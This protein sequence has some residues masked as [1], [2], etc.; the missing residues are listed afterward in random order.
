MSWRT[1]ISGL[2][3]VKQALVLDNGIF[4]MRV[5]KS[6]SDV[7]ALHQNGICYIA[8]GYRHNQDFLSALNTHQKSG[9]L[10]GAA[11]KF[12]ERAL[13][14]LKELY[15]GAARSAG[16]KENEAASTAGRRRLLRPIEHA[17]DM[18]AS[19][20]RIIKHD[21]YTAV[22]L[23]V[24]GRELGYGH[25]WTAEEGEHAISG[26]FSAQNDGSGETTQA[27]NAFQS[28]SISSSDKFPLPQNVGKLRVQT[29]YHES[30]VNMGQSL[31]A[32]VFYTETKETG[33]LD[34]LGLDR[35][36]LGAFERAR[37]NL[38]GA[39]II[40]GETGDGKST[41]LVRALEAVYDFHTGSRSIATLEDP[42]EYRIRRDGIMQIPLKSAGDELKRAANYRKALLNFMRINPDVGMISEIR[43]GAGGRELLQFV[44]S[45]HAVYSTIHVGK[46]F[47]IPFRMISLGVPPEEICQ[48]GIVRIFMKQTLVRLLCDHCKIPMQAMEL[49]EANARALAPL[50]AHEH[51]IY[52]RNTEG[53]EHCRKDLSETGARAWAGLQRLIAVAEV[54][55]PDDTFNSFIRSGDANGAY[56]HWVSPRSE[57]GMGGIEIEAKMT[58]LVLAG[59]LDPFDCLG[60]K[61]DLSKGLCPDARMTLRTGSAG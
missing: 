14:D 3:R 53:C 37:I 33:T 39:V 18:Q 42:V 5:H 58:E 45:G 40:G 52:M 28:F 29:G 49:S 2:S 19:D 4:D 11:P 36:V 20:I 50:R 23:R 17:A 56:A 60:S 8:K 57:G 13:Q 26:A 10:P 32:R 30:D 31:T 44:Q 43:D 51:A 46:A 9:L 54:I 25:N 41:T 59:Q 15:E 16:R 6:F 55:E 27:V 21:T 24:A 35:E 1:R 34:D 47:Q 48:T 22:R 12:E 38:K 61:G 7:A